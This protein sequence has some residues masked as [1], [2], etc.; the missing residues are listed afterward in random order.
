MDGRDF[1]TADI[2]GPPVAL[3]NETLAKTFF[4]DQ[5][6]LGRRLKP[7]FGAQVRWFTII[8]VVSE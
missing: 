4:R 3:V 5:N 1:T 6:P 2:G 7:G 8:G